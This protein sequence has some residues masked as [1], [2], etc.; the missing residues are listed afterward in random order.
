MEDKF[1]EKNYRKK[2]NFFVIITIRNIGNKKGFSLDTSGKKTK[3]CFSDYV[4]KIYFYINKNLYK[5]VSLYRDFFVAIIL[6]I[7]V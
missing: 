4:N 2:I 3:C 6:M 5:D 1:L 7:Y